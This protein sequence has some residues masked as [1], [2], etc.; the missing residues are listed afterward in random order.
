[1]QDV[2]DNIDQTSKTAR[3]ELADIARLTKA[4]L[5]ELTGIIQ[6][7]HQIT[8]KINQGDGTASKLLNDPKLYEGLVDTTQELKLTIQDLQRL[9]QQWEQE[10]VTLKLK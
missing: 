1:M 10:G 6:Q 9:V 5:E 7:A 3:T 4:R 2:V 8:T